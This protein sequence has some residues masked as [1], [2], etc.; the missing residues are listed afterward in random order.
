MKL[1]KE[2]FAAMMKDA[3]TTAVKAEV[4]ARGLENIDRK[5]VSGMSG[6]SEKEI[7]AM[8]GKQKAALFFK[9]IMRNDVATLASLKAMTEGTGSQGGFLVPDEFEATVMRLVEDFGI[10]RKLSTVLPM[11]SD[12]LRVPR[13]ATTVT[14][15]FPGEATAATASD[16]VFAE[17]VL[18]AKT[19]IGI[20]TMSNEF[21]ADANVNVIDIIAQLFAEAIAGAEDTQGLVGTGSPFT[22]VLN[23]AG[24]TVLTPAAGNSTFTLCSTPDNFR[25]LIAQV[26]PWAL[27]NAAFIMHRA[28]WSI[29]QQKKASTGGDYF[30]SVA[31][32]VVQGDNLVTGSNFGLKVAGYI[33]GFPVYLSDKMPNTTAVSTKYV[34]FGNLKNALLGDRSGI[35]VDISKDATVSTS[36]MF[37]RNMSAVRVIR[38]FAFDVGLPAAFA[39]LATSAT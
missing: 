39:V 24:V 36:N 19:C 9:S 18:S 3:V 38:R 16:P 28:I 22:G 31:N 32:P 4:E 33:W 13:L 30:V 20:T 5:F 10:I 1:T 34:I 25:D 37:E 29:L 23:N 2:E 6:V 26:K 8:D 21:L 11:G 35:A 15:S 27:Q 14:V 12:T 17:A 7:D